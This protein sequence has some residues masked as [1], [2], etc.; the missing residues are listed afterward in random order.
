VTTIVIILVAI[1]PKNIINRLISVKDVF[2]GFLAGYG[3]YM[4]DYPIN[5]QIIVSTIT[6]ICMAISAGRHVNRQCHACGTLHRF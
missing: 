2:V 1:F 3:T 4:Y 6:I 5:T